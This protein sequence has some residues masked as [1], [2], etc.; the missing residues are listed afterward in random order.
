MIVRLN[1][2]E[3]FILT[4]VR[5]ENGYTETEESE[6]QA[7]ALIGLLDYSLPHSTFQQMQEMLEHVFSLSIDKRASFYEDCLEET[8]RRVIE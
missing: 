8:K 3:P 1:S 4:A 6:L 2:L 7:K 5:S